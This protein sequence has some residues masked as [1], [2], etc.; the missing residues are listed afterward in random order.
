MLKR[1][2]WPAVCPGLRALKLRR[3][4]K[5]RRL[6]AERRHELHPDGEPFRGPVKRHG[7]GRVARDI[8]RRG[9]GGVPSQCLEIG[10]DIG[11]HHTNL[12]QLVRG[13]THGGCEQDV[14]AGEKAADDPAHAMHRVD[15]LGIIAR[16]ELACILCCPPG[17]GL[18]ILRRRCASKHC[19]CPL[20]QN[21]GLRGDDDPDGL[22]TPENG[23]EGNPAAIAALA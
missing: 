19:L 20:E 16:G 4:T 18:D 2:R 23:P 6:I 21:A 17:D 15:G 10:V 14:V 8:E 7:H 12:A 1:L 3:Q 22:G 11:G 5:E 9:K 13:R